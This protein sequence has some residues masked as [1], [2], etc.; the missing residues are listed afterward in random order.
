MDELAVFDEG[1]DGHPNTVDDGFPG[2]EE[3]IL[4]YWGHNLQKREETVFVV[5]HCIPSFPPT[6]IPTPGPSPLPSFPPTT[7]P[8]PMPSAN[9]TPSPSPMPSTTPTP[10]PSPMPSTQPS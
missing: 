10:K 3:W 5:I 9:P 8:S 6:N 7:L 4:F 1:T 2:G